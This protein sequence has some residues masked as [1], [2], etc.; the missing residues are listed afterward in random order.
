MN[1]LHPRV[2]IVWR[3][4]GLLAAAI[5][6]A[7]AGLFE[8]A[9]LLPQGDALIYPGFLVGLVALVSIALA[10]FWPRL[11]YR[12]W[13]WLVEPDRVLIQKG[14]LWRSRSLL[15][16]VRIQHVDTRSS[17]LQRWLG[18]ATLIIYTAGTRGA[19]AEIPGLAAEQAEQLREELARLEELDDRA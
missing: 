4:T 10:I 8:V 15:P 2:T 17:P 11:R 6:T 18:L 7:L 5:L 1:Q 16:R 14:V 9:V 3:V 13:R 12:Y 19:D